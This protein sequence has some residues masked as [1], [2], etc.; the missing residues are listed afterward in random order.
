METKVQKLLQLANEIERFKFCG[1]SDDPDEQTAVV[2]GYKHLAKKFLNRARRIQHNEFQ[3]ALQD[4]DPNI[5]QIY[6]AYDLHSDLQIVIEDLREI[7]DDSTK[8]TRVETE[9]VD[10]SVIKELHQIKNPNFDLTKVIR[11]CDEING[12]FNNGYYLSTALLIRAL[13]NHIPPVFGYETFKQVVSQ[14]TKSRKELFK[15]L[16][17]TVRDVAD[18]HSHDIIRKKEHLPTK[19]QLEPFKPNLE[20]LLQEIITELKISE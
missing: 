14:S 11:F 19:R 8:L 2:Y 12:S 15:P 3:M 20:I 1:P 9:F 6:E 18:L 16:E 17:E 4:I 13:I 10:S 7:A 5:E